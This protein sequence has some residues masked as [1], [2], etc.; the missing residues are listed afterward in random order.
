MHEASWV[1]SI[2]LYVMC[3]V[4]IALIGIGAVGSVVGLVHTVA[5]DL[6]H[7]DTLDRVGIGL[8]NIA[9][10]V[11]DLVG[12]TQGGNPEAFCRDVTESQDEFDACVE[13]EQSFGG[14]DEMTAIQDGIGEVKDELRTQIRNSSVDQM[15]KGI[16]LVGVGLLLF[17][18]HSS[19]TELFADG[20][21]PRRG[22]PAAGAAP[23]TPM[24]RE[25]PTDPLP[26]PPGAP[27]P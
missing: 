11:V 15:I 27:L 14:G 18:I 10:S 7:R 17:R 9:T 26:P 6:G 8:A 12:E 24:A 19:R 16:L 13:E 1:R 2:Y 23:P 4:S 5:P 3:A 20:L 21:M 22:S 25:I